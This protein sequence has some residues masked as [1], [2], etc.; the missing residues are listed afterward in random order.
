[1]LV[2]VPRHFKGIDAA[3]EVRLMRR[4]LCVEEFDV[5][6]LEQTLRGSEADIDT[7]RLAANTC[8]GNLLVE[9]FLNLWRKFR[10]ITK[11]L[12]EGRTEGADS[13]VVGQGIR[14]R[15]VVLGS[16]VDQRFERRLFETLLRSAFV[17]DRLV[18]VEFPL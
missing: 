2:G 4:R 17:I 8:L 13:L 7:G 14:G 6:S 10:S 9:E 15:I 18:K 11:I 1:M 3:A 16:S 5:R 12:S